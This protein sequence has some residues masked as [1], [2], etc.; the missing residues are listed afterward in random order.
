[1]PWAHCTGR[2]SSWRWMEKNMN[3]W[4][5]LKKIILVGQW[6]PSFW[7]WVSLEVQCHEVNYGKSC[8]LINRSPPAERTTGSMAS[9]RE[10]I[11]PKT[12]ESWQFGNCGGPRMPR[13]TLGGRSGGTI[14]MGAHSTR[15]QL[16]GSYWPRAATSSLP[17]SS[18]NDGGSFLPKECW[19]T[20]F[21]NNL[22]HNE[23]AIQDHL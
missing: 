12:P 15:A 2:G 3:Q 6:F 9:E 10:R 18:P 22:R 11:F 23:P 21:P 7:L 14:V 19:S 17:C 8:D 5:I 13:V 16:Q 20:F 1:M 4:S